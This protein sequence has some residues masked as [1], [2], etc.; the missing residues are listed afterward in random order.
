MN[1]PKTSFGMMYLL[2][3][4]K[5]PLH[6]RHAGTQLRGTTQLEGIDSFHSFVPIVA[7]PK[8]PNL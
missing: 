3:Q 1:Y 5:K 6:V 8:T 4:I 7:Q 2:H